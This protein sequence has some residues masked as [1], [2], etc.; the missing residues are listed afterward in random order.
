MGGLKPVL[1]TGIGVRDNVLLVEVLK[2]IFKGIYLRVDVCVLRIISDGI[3]VLIVLQIIEGEVVVFVEVEN[4]VI[5][6]EIKVTTI[7]FSGEKL[8]VLGLEEITILQ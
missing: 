3:R 1:S 8:E 2:R 4:F 7:R 6:N 5:V